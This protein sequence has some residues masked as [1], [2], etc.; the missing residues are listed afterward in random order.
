MTEPFLKQLK[1]MLD[2]LLPV[3]SAGGH[4]FFSLAFGCTGGRHRSVAITEI[5]RE[6]LIQSGFDPLIT[7]RDIKQ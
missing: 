6:H 3:Y 7:H 4:S 5:I 2:L 1:E